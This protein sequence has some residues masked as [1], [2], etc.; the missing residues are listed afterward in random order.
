MNIREL[1][2]KQ[3]KAEST[4]LGLLK[5]VYYDHLKELSDRHDIHSYYGLEECNKKVDI[6]YYVDHCF[7]GSRVW[8]LASVWYENQPVMVIQNAGRDGDDHSKRFITDEKLYKEMLSYIVSLMNIDTSTAEEVDA[9]VDMP[10]LTNFYG[11]DMSY[12]ETV[13][14]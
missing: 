10:E 6:R 12:V 11:Y 7:R 1:Y 14:D 5:G 8:V 4:C 3:H 2:E 9:D 13:F